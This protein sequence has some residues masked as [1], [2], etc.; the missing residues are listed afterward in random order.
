MSQTRSPPLLPK[1]CVCGIIQKLRTKPRLVTH[2]RAASCFLNSSSVSPEPGD[3]RCACKRGS[4][5]F[6]SSSETGS[7][8]DITPMESQISSTNCSFSSAVKSL[9]CGISASV[10]IHN[11]SR[12]SARAKSDEFR[13]FTAKDTKGGIFTTKAPRLQG[14]GK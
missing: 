9:I 13:K 12:K 7:S 3:G 2:S 6:F 14:G 1:E 4:R 5:S 8:S 11:H 10:M